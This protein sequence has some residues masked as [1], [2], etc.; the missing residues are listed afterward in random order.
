MKEKNLKIFTD[1]IDE[2]ALGQIHTLMEQEAFSD[3]KVRIMPDVHAGS[4]C[5]IGFTSELG[6]KIV[7]NIVGVDIGCGMLTVEL[8]NIDINFKDL[9]TVI[10]E[11]IPSGFDVFDDEQELDINLEELRAFDKIRK[12]SWIKRSM[13]TLGGGNHFIEVGQDEEGNKYLVIH[14]GSRNLGLQ[15][16]KYYQN[17]A[18]ESLSRPDSGLRDDLIKRLKAE[19]RQREISKE[20]KK[21]KP[22]NIV[23]KDL[24]YLE[25]QNAQDYLHDMKMAQRYA[26]QNRKEMALAICV[27]MGWR[28]VSAFETVHNYIGEDNIVRKGAISAYAGEKVLIPINMRDGCIIGIGKGNEDWNYSAPHGAGRIMSRTEAHKTLSLET[29]EDDM[30]NVYTSTAVQATLDESPR[31]YKPM[32]EIID[33]IQDTVEVIKIIK[34]IYNYKAVN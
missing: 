18:I 10:K 33:N 4:G 14:S 19:G 30:K 13:G 12:I 21:L 9:D 28:V 22:K 3:L 11:Y 17:L 34:P 20:L 27:N 32:Q 7:P 8:G 24:A 23:P 25:G 5:V 29:F 26:S 6:D 16:A 15:I 1:N 31:A 2:K